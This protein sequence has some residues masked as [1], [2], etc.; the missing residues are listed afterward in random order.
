LL[1]G[2]APADAQLRATTYASGFSSPIAFVQDPANPAIQYVAEQG[3]IIRVIRNG[4]VETTPFL[5]L[6][7]VIVSGGETGLLG[8]AFAPDYATSGHFYV[9]FTRRLTTQESAG[10]T[11]IL[12]PTDLAT[13]VA[14][15]TRS[16]NPLVADPASRRD[17]AWSTGKTFIPQPYSNHNAGCLEFGPDGY[18]YV[19]VGDGGSGDDPQNYAQNAASLLGKI[20]RIDVS[21]P[22][23]HPT[24][25][26]VPAGNAGLTRPEIWS[27]GLRNPWKFSFDDPRR[28]GT[29]AMLIADVGQGALEEV[30][31]EPSGRAGRNYGWRNYEGTRLNVNTVPLP[32][33]PTFPIF[34]YGH[35]V[36]RSITGG[37]VYRGTAVPTL[38]GRYFFGDYVTR[39]VWSL[40][41]NLNGTSGEASPSTAADLLDH[42]A[43]LGGSA[44]LGGISAFGL[45]AAGELYVINHSAGVILKV[46][47][48]LPSPPTNV[49]IIR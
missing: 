49:R 2:A 39:R 13:V 47:N 14:R 1:I 25:F 5:N 4:V 41:L 15:F 21:V 45:D 19:A 27:L 34:E 36:G 32:S 9:N 12:T 3:G 6:S 43:E 35:S 46:V 40:R 7:S 23:S 31:H 22:G 28:G 44:T 30:N 26:V 17:L 42:T 24:G 38:R 48:G 10:V 16:S 20:L 8:L 29:G 18:L 37:N 11:E 33:S